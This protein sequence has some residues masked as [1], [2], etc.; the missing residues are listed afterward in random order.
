M[1][2]FVPPCRYVHA[3]GSQVKTSDPRGLELQSAVSHPVGA[4]G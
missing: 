2:E 4:E 3:C 1:Y